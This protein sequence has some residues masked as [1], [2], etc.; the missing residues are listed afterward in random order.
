MTQSGYFYN[1][2]QFHQFNFYNIVF[3][4]DNELASTG[5]P[6]CAK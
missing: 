6:Q 3:T 4:P 2:A 1:L 5:M